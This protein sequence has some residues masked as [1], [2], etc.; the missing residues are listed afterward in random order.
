MSS[1]FGGGMLIGMISV[2]LLPRPP[3]AISGITMLTTF[4]FLPAG[5]ILLGLPAP[6]RVSLVVIF[7]MGT[8]FGYVNIYLLSWLQ[9]RTPLHLLGRI[10]AVVLFS[11]IGLSPVSQALM[12]YLFDLNLQATLIGVGSLVLLVLILTSTQREMWSLAE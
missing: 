9:R 11:T 1:A 6:I 7:I 12:G 8:T 2:K 10:M 3:Q 5:L 4:A